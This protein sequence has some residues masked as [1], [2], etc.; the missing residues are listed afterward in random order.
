VK[1]EHCEQ[2]WSIYNL[3]CLQIEEAEQDPNTDAGKIF[4]MELDMA[5]ELKKHEAECEYCK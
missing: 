3:R 4:Q 2:Y 1:W 5:N